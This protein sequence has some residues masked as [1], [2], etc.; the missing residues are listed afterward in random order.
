MVA[1]ETNTLSKRRLMMRLGLL[2]LLLILPSAS[3]SILVARDSDVTGL[4]PISRRHG[5]D[6]GE[7]QVP[8]VDVM[9]RLRRWAVGPGP[10]ASPSSQ[11]QEEQDLKAARALALGH[12]RRH[13]Y[14]RRDSEDE[15]T[16]SKR[17]SEEEEDAAATAPDPLITPGPRYPPCLAGG[18]ALGRRQNDGQIQALS[19]EIQRL[20]Q[21]FDSA[22]QA[23]R[24]VS[25]ASQQLSQSVQQLSQSTARFQA[26]ARQAQESARRAEDNARQA[27]E[28]ANRAS[29][30]A[31]SAIASV[32]S[33]ASSALSSALASASSSANA[34][35]AQASRDA[36][37]IQD[38]AASQ[39]EAARADATLA[40]TEANTQVSQAQGAAV[41]V[42]QA[43]LAVVGTF[44]ASSLLS[45]AVFYLILR[46]RNR[47][48]DSKKV[49][50]V[51]RKISA[52]TQFRK[53]ESGLGA[54][55]GS[56]DNLMRRNDAPA[57]PAPMGM[58]AP[59]YNVGG[60]PRDVKPPVALAAASNSN[61]GATTQYAA[62]RSSSIY[63]S[64]GAVVGNPPAVAKFS[65]FPKS[66]AATSGPGSPGFPPDKRSSRGSR[67]PS[68]Q[69]W[70]KAGAVSPFG[71]MP[72][73]P[74]SGNSINR[75]A[76][77][78]LPKPTSGGPMM[79]PRTKLPFRED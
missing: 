68:L 27:G 71:T 54:A 79:Q 6:S 69:Q 51:R 73:N 72:R 5:G 57:G 35:M 8:V 65:I 2:S 23:S 14:Q 75:P 77:G 76:V 66:S 43:A 46:C 24:S 28:A 49:G 11:E 53:T 44:I 12:E 36:A 78:R 32:S 58:P 9:E 50:G 63:D 67:P 25:Q 45:I 26:D 48:R 42:T 55:Y 56:T 4:Q 41:S 22:T 21:S 30:S 33:S 62:N 19:G 29:Q 3:G 37:R 40:R 70:L 39:V 61:S 59:A 47:N 64:P 17:E 31:S 34:A 52:P 74:L 38:Q 16:T 13:A 18:H 7:L 15:P 1:R 20:S 10:A 60:Y